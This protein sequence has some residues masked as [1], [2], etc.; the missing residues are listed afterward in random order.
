CNSSLSGSVMWVHPLSPQ[1]SDDN[2]AFIYGA[3]LQMRVSQHLKLLAEV[4]SASSIAQGSWNNAGDA[5]VGYG[6]RFFD[7]KLAGDVGF[8]RRVGVGST[9]LLLGVP[10]VNFTVRL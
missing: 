2:H 1:S 10:F 6:V 7:A 3:N 5:L 8:L 9:N 4:D